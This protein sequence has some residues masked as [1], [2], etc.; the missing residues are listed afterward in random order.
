MRALTAP[1]VLNVMAPSHTV[2]CANHDQ[3]GNWQNCIRLMME[4]GPKTPHYPAPAPAPAPA[5]VLITLTS[6]CATKRQARI[7]RK[8]GGRA[9]RWPGIASTSG[10]KTP[11]LRHSMLKMIIVY[12]DRLGTNIGNTR[13]Q[14][15]MFSYFLQGH[16]EGPP[17]LLGAPRGWKRLAFYY[18]GY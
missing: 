8:G 7:I 18:G 2:M 17:A 14:K 3:P 12:Q 6:V 9:V 5:V 10:K 15:E 16:R 13:L 1:I 11:S 4:G